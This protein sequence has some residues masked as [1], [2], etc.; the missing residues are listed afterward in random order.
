MDR[1]QRDRWLFS[2][3]EAAQGVRRTLHESRS[4]TLID[5]GTTMPPALAGMVGELPKAPFTLKDARG[6]AGSDGTVDVPFTR[7]S[8]DGGGS[9]YRVPGMGQRAGLGDGG[10]LRGHEDGRY[11]VGQLPFV[12]DV[13]GEEVEG[14]LL[15]P[16]EALGWQSAD[17]ASS[18][19]Q[20]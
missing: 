19:S 11:P 20:M 10:L 2:Q 1:K 12:V 3:W 4:N 7:S 5:P 17:P 13:S 15:K 6:V 8:G 14:V 16:A 9:Q 18:G